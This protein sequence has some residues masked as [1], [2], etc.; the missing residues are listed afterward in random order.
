EQG[1]RSFTFH[2][3]QSADVLFTT[4][5]VD[6]AWFANQPILHFCSNTL[7]TTDIANCTSYIVAQARAKQAMVSFDVNLRHN[8]WPDNQIDISLVNQL[9]HQADIVKFS[10]DE[11]EFLAG[12]DP[13][14]YLQDCL[15]AHC[16]LLVITDGANPIRFLTRAAQGNIHPP[17][18]KAVDTTAGGDAFIGGL[19]F[20]LS[21]QADIQSVCQ[22]SQQLATLLHFAAA[23]GAHTVTQPGAFTA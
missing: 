12:A 18:V 9:V 23:C 8:L 21:Q 10:R 4:E 3:H 13:E 11:L 5:Q 22:D 19:L 2:R 16:Q 1:E 7:T 20:G 15:A 6:S 14:Q 17:V